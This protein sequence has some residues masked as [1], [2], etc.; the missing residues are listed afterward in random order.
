[1]KLRLH[2]NSVRLRVSQA[3]MAKFVAA[4]TVREVIQFGPGEPFSYGLEALPSVE[5]VHA[6]YSPGCLRICVPTRLA[7]E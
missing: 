3:D 5:R 1:M 4:G 6:S 2:N 7:E